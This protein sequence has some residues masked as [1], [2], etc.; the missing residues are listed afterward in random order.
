VDTA[1]R[2]TRL[3]FG[4]AVYTEIDMLLAVEGD[5]H[6]GLAVIKAEIILFGCDGMG[7]KTYFITAMVFHV[8]ANLKFIGSKFFETQ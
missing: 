4:V 5:P 2:A 7:E 3:I 6:G 8:F 1:G